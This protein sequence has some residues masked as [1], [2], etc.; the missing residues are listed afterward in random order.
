MPPY[1]P[2][3][4]GLAAAHNQE[5]QRNMANNDRI[6]VYKNNRPYRHYSDTAS[7]QHFYSPDSTARQ[8]E[9]VQPEP[10]FYPDPDHRVEAPQPATRPAPK[11][12]KRTKLKRKPEFA[13]DIQARHRHNFLS[14][15]LVLAF[16]GGLALVLAL[17][18]R[19]EYD[20]VALEAERTQLAALQSGNAARASEIYATL[21]LEQ[22]EAFA[23]ERL[24]M[25]PPEDFQ[26]VEIAVSPQS[27]FS[28]SPADT[29]VADS[30]SFN[31]FL[32]VLFSFDSNG[33]E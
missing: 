1:F 17:N 27:F 4:G 19:F 22:I 13:H 3:R 7:S 10:V 20:R 28:A 24:G 11:S 8:V 29:P 16:F 6:Q 25:V 26:L 33:Q 14:Y 31:R 15:V 18:A 32:N 12:R 9:L 23:I 2:R 30:F 5:V 21:N